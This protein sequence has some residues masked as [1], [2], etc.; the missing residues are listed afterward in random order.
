MHVKKDS[1]FCQFQ[2]NKSLIVS[3]VREGKGLSERDKRAEVP[4]W[5]SW[6]LSRAVI[7]GHTI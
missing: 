3:C 5:K 1:R 6:L 7:C 4:P 2:R